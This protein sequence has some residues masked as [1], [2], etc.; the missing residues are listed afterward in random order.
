MQTIAYGKRF[1]P[2]MHA[3]YDFLILL[4]H[5]RRQLLSTFASMHL[6]CMVIELLSLEENFSANQIVAVDCRQRR[7]VGSPAGSGFCTSMNSV[8]YERRP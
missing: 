4:A 3:E 5:N 8:K 6:Q 7:A 1:V 2:M